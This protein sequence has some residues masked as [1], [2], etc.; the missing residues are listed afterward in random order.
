MEGNTGKINKEKD[1]SDR[2]L[3]RRSMWDGTDGEIE[4]AT[5]VVE[6]EQNKK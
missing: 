4:I 1:E 2:G 5:S 3:R 6:I